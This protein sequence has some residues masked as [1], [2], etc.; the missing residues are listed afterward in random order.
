MTHNRLST[1]APIPNESPIGVEE[2]PD[3]KT[4]GFDHRDPE[5]RD[6]FRLATHIV[7]YDEALT[8]VLIKIAL[9]KAE[10]NATEEA[11]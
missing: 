4:E 8:K 10:L 3:H 11:G 6:L 7:Q 1:V 9:R 2:L 5:E